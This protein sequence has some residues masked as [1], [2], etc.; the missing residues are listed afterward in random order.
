MPA[1]VQV[2]AVIWVDAQIIVNRVNQRGEL[3][4]TLPGGRVNERE[5]VIDALKREVLEEVGI[6]ITVGDLM[7]AAEV[8]SS[9]RR[10]DVELVFAAQPVGE[11][12]P[13]AVELVDPK[14]PSC[15]VMP[16][17][18]DYIAA[19]RDGEFRYRWLGNIYMTQATVRSQSPEA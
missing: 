10:Q 8:F 14:R 17:V 19:S 3:H 4:V 11:T 12:L 6:E 15:T 9:A 13:V 16:P 2:R 18:L 7:F 5:S 1:R